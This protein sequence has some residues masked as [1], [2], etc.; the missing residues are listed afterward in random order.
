MEVTTHKEEFARPPV[1]PE[2]REEDPRAA[3]ARRAAEIR[4]HLGSM[5]S[6]TDEFWAP[7]PP[8]GWTYEW[9]TRF[10]QNMELAT[11]INGFERVGW[12]AVPA[13]RH[14]EMMPSGGVFANI[15]RKGMILMERPSVIVDE[16]REIDKIRARAQVTGKEAQL[17][18]S[19]QGTFQRD[20]ATLKKSF[21]PIP[22]PKD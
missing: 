9:K 11:R 12:T 4:G 20:K 15:E 14:P 18:A 8:D 10:V 1:R 2:I 13:S 21:E 17:N 6:G 7:Q 5:D 3:A 22:V 16:A 19:P